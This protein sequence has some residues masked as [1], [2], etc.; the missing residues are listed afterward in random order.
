MRAWPAQYDR[1]S[2]VVLP[3][4]VKSA[5]P[6]IGQ[7]HL[8]GARLSRVQGSTLTTLSAMGSDENSALSITRWVRTWGRRIGPPERVRGAAGGLPRERPRRLSL[9]ITA[10]RETPILPAICAQDSPSVT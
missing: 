4:K 2:A 9:P 3:Q 7:R 1:P 5:A 8:R 6:L 10:L